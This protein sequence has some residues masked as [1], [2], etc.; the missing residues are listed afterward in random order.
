MSSASFIASRTAYDEAS[1]LLARY[2]AGAASEAA[3]RAENS[4]EIGNLMQFCHWRQTERAI[5]IMIGLD[6]P[7]EV[8]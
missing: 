1:E 3:L 7:G 8:H 2:G 5:A 6:A 4:R